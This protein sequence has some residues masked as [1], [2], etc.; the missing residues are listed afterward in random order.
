METS[1]GL[2]YFNITEWSPPT[3]MS[4]FIVM[5]HFYCP[6]NNIAYHMDI[7]ITMPPW[8]I[9]Y[10]EALTILSVLTWALNSKTSS[11]WLLIYMDSINM[12]EIFHS[13]STL[14]GYYDLLM[15]PVGLLIPSLSFL[16]VLHVLGAENLLADALSRGSLQSH[17]HCI[18]DLFSGC[19]SPHQACQ[20]L[21]FNEHSKCSDL[22]TSLHCLVQWA[23][24]VQALALG[25]SIEHST[26]IT[27]TSH[28]QSYLTFC[29]LHNCPIYPTVDTL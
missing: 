13:L 12:V 26:T 27:Y 5:H 3:L 18:P 20:G 7:S 21:M 22:A 2:F 28:L 14:P 11:R 17:Y 19:F 4:S 6:A 23:S 16:Q 15:H 29:K 25:H 9:F 1:I 10:Q 24:P 8:M